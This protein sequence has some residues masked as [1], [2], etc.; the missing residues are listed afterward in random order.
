MAGNAIPRVTPKRGTILDLLAARNW[1]Q[2]RLAS[3]LKIN[4]TLLAKQLLGR[5]PMDLVTAVLIA[6]RL[7][8]EWTDIVEAECPTC[9]VNVGPKRRVHTH[10][11]V[12]A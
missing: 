7:D 1:S 6:A 4:E 10:E 3:E 11:E 5:R 2:K 8:V 12:A 9:G